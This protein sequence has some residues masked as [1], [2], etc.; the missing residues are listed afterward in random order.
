ARS[1]W[2][3]LV[4]DAMSAIRDAEEAEDPEWPERG[5][6]AEV[7]RRVLPEIDSRRSETELLRLAATEW[8]RHPGSA[9]FLSRAEAAIGEIIQ[10]NKSLRKTIQNLM[11]EGVSL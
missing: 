9:T 4:A 10:A 2:M 11:R 5:W 3:T 8:R 1:V 6:H 7:L